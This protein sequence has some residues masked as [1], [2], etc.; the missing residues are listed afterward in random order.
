M[1]TLTEKS[2]NPTPADGRTHRQEL[3]NEALILPNQITL[4]L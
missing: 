1:E 3:I 4:P 2:A